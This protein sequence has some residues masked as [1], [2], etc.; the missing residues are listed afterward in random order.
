MAEANTV[1]RG[2]LGIRQWQRGKKDKVGGYGL[3]RSPETAHN[4]ED[5][6]TESMLGGPEPL[7]G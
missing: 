5:I 4:Y 1:D 2:D 7:A 3:V 6:P